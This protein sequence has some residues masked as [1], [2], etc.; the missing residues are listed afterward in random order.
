VPSVVVYGHRRMGK[1]S[2]LHNLGARFGAQTVIVD[3]NMQRVGRVRSNAQLLYQLA[4]TMFD[5]CEQHGIQP[6]SGFAE[7]QEQDFAEDSPG[8]G[9]SR[10][11]S[12]LERVRD[13]RRFI[14]TVDEFEK[15]EEQME[16][17]RLT[18]DLLDFWR[19]TFMTYPWFIMAFAGLYTLEERRHD[20]WNPLFG[21]VNA[22]RVSFLSPAAA[23]RLI[24]QPTPDFDLDYDEDAV[25]EIITLTGGQPFLIQLIGHSLVSRFN[26]QVFEQGQPH[27]RRFSL[28]DVQTVIADPAF[29]S[30]G[31]AYFH[32]VWNQAQQSEP[33]G[34]TIILRV[35]APHKAGLTLDDLVRSTGLDAAQVQAALH[36]LLQHDIVW[37]DGERYGFAVELMRRWAAG[38]EH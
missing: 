25:A 14:I 11:L 7:P 4:V 33:D 23:Q 22:I 21:S 18:P 19:G 12:R 10:F 34:Q 2:I 32:G 3:F 17:G 37:R 26:Q 24:V 31:S 29:A 9:F 35:L 8:F 13:G 5:A 20:Y 28:A 30:D 36:T 15:L 1:S 27:E 38:M 6:A 16:E